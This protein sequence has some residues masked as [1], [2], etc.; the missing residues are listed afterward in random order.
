MTQLK[1]ADPAK[2][3]E[4]L[5]AAVV[6]GTSS[7]KRS[8]QATLTQFVDH[9]QPKSVAIERKDRTAQ[10]VARLTRL[11][12]FGL[13]ETKRSLQSFIEEKQIGC[14][15]ETVAQTDLFAN[16]ALD[17]STRA[18][19][20][21][22]AD[23]YFKTN[24]LLFGRAKAVLSLPTILYQ[25][26]MES[27]SNS[28]LAPFFSDLVLLVSGEFSVR[29]LD[30]A[31]RTFAKVF[32]HE[33]QLATLHFNAFSGTEADFAK[34]V[35][36]VFELKKLK[37]A[38]VFGFCCKKEV[39]LYNWK[40]LL[41]K[42]SKTVLEKARP[43]ELDFLRRFVFSKDESPRVL[44]HVLHHLVAVSKPFQALLD[45]VEQKRPFFSLHLPSKTI[46]TALCRDRTVLRAEVE[47]LDS[48]YMSTRT[49]SGPPMLSGGRL[50]SKPEGATYR[51]ELAERFV[52][53]HKGALLRETDSRLD[54]LFLDFCFQ[55]N[56][57]TEEKAGRFAGAGLAG[58]TYVG[59]LAAT[60]CFV[61]RTPFQHYLVSGNELQALSTHR[62][63][64]VLNNPESDGT[65]LAE[66]Y[67]LFLAQSD[68]AGALPTRKVEGVYKR[69]NAEILAGF[70][71]NLIVHQTD[72]AERCTKAATVVEST[73]PL[74]AFC[75]LSPESATLEEDF[76]QAADSELGF[77][78]FETLFQKCEVCQDTTEVGEQL[79][80]RE[81]HENVNHSKDVL[82]VSP[83]F[84]RVLTDSAEQTKLALPA[85]LVAAY[86][87]RRF[88][89]AE[90][91]VTV[92]PK[93]A[94]K[95]FSARVY[96]ETLLRHEA[97]CRLLQQTLDTI[98]A[99][100]N[101][102]QLAHA[103]ALLSFSVNK[104]VT[105]ARAKRMVAKTETLL[106][107]DV[108]KLFWI[109][110]MRAVLLDAEAA[111]DTN[112]NGAKAFL[113]SKSKRPIWLA[114]L[115]AAFSTR[116][117]T[118]LSKELVFGVAPVFFHKQFLFAKFRGT[119][120]F[121]L[122]AS[123]AY[124]DDNVA[125]DRFLYEFFAKKKFDPALLETQHKCVGAPGFITEA[126]ACKVCH[127]KESPNSMLVCDSC[128]FATHMACLKLE[129][130]RAPDEKW[131][132]ESC[133]PPLGSHALD[134]RTLEKAEQRL[135]SAARKQ[136]K[137]DSEKQV[138]SEEEFLFETQKRKRESLLNEDIL[139]EEEKLQQRNKQKTNQKKK[140]GK[141]PVKTNTKKVKRNINLDETSESELE[142]STESE[143]EMSMLGKESEQETESNEEYSSN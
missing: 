25:A 24:A 133:C 79:H 89:L 106:Q 95:A 12:C 3:R 116:V 15:D 45:F 86:I 82:T 29:K 59:N 56:L 139:V 101:E 128:E 6:G 83:S 136:S 46:F 8:A 96:S 5:A 70:V 48:L 143:E 132:C 42:Q 62:L 52:K 98:E 67:K 13:P 121:D 21:L 10:L 105:V 35:S 74:K 141:K 78:S 11:Q 38:F 85:D 44:V 76:R 71:C 100:H 111:L 107:S 129:V 14:A 60:S 108:A 110:L 137:T 40:K 1:T 63:V 2:F 7:R 125:Y 80:C 39:N 123:L 51:K 99:T 32:E 68:V 113:N 94:N 27:V 138:L 134:H 43:G 92:F 91:R 41:R 126:D 20:L 135:R 118:M 127:S 117:L 72:L 26:E 23:S 34:L 77:C 61:L 120:K 37:C 50:V 75:V 65:L 93:V 22:L 54:T 33:L 114:R 90:G 130:A 140:L 19:L 31:V 124:F 66:C 142:F 18:K 16:S 115:K 84:F 28:L 109:R 55:Q 103:R 81:C 87:Q 4:R 104:L 64:A 131:F 57:Y 69:E 119:L 73:E 97:H 53:K 9:S 102:N 30:Q 36:L 112:F 17:G 88:P 58:L 47:H 49:R 122:L